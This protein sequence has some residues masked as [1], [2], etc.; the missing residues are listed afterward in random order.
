MRVF[1][2]GYCR[3]YFKQIGLFNSQIYATARVLSFDLEQDLISSACSEITVDKLANSVTVGDVCFVTNES[4]EQLF[5]GIIESIDGNKLT[6]GDILK[7][8]E[9][10][11]VITPP[12]YKV[13]CKLHEYPQK[14]FEICKAGSMNTNVDNLE[15]SYYNNVDY[16]VINNKNK[17]IQRTF[18]PFSTINTYEVLKNL[19]SQRN[20]VVDVDI[21][22]M[23]LA[24]N[25][26]II[27]KYV[28]DKFIYKIIDNS[29]YTVNF[30]FEEEMTPVNKLAIWK[31]IDDNNF[32][33]VKSVFLTPSGLITKADDPT[34]LRKIKSKNVFLEK[35]ATDADVQK[36]IDD[37]IE[38]TLYLHQIEIEL[39]ADNTL[40]DWRKM[41]LGER[42]EVFAN[43][44]YYKTVLTGIKLKKDSLANEMR[45]FLVF[46]KSRTKLTDLV[47]T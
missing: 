25:N 4:G 40:Y 10:E 47:L 42:Y 19:Y 45:I 22:L 33:F 28:G 14:V 43:N 38:D 37:N 13:N 16:E 30:S 26:K 15:Y 9:D 12:Y 2:D 3:A 7:I 39:I 23:P 34:R 36:A 35:D 29:V 24:R 44:K 31:K 11:A 1:N 8:Y 27:S 17:D 41:E 21:P 46:G 32:N 20:L 6:L 18:E 5:K